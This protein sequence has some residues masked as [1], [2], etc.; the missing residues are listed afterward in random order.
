M[1]WLVVSSEKEGGLLENLLAGWRGVDT[2]REGVIGAGSHEGG[3]VEKRLGV[4]L[5][6][7]TLWDGYQIQAAS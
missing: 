3:G 7:K 6:V 1:L 4:E 2:R 5:N